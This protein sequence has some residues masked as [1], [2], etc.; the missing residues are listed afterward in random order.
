MICDIEYCDRSKID[1]K[2]KQFTFGYLCEH[3]FNGLEKF[4]KAVPEDVN[5]KS[6]SAQRRLW[7]KFKISQEGGNAR[8]RGG[9]NLV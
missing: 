1:E 3:H 5:I 2:G 4:L 6:K 9:P 7:I 8:D